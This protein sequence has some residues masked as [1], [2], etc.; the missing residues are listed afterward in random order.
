[1]SALLGSALALQRFCQQQG[2]QFCFIGGL[3]VQRWGEPSLTLDANMT[4][5]TGFGSEA[6]YVDLLLARFQERIPDARAFALGHRV[7]LLQSDQGIPLDIALGAMPFE[8]R[9]VARASLHEIVPGYRLMTCAAEDLIVHK[10]FAD[11]PKDWL[12]IET[13]VVRQR[14]RLD[15]QLVWDELLP[16]AELKE[17]PGI[18]AR[19]R[20][21]IERP[22]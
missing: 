8:E 13:I 3:A 9:T 15:L 5:L 10:A 21:M 19:L 12:D 14:G 11:W 22:Q 17:D 7:L 4:L 16:L 2:W 20:Q 6:T 1:M 18:V